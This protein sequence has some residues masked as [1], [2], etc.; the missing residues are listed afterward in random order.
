VVEECDI[1]K[2]LEKKGWKPQEGLH[3][4]VRAVKPLDH[5]AVDIMRMPNTAER[6]DSV[7]IV[8]DSYSRFV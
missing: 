8:V 4:I 2:D 7:L 5:L 6:Y 1:C 3:L